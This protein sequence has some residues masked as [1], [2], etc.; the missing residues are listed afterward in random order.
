[1]PQYTQPSPPPPHAMIYGQVTAQ[2]RTREITAGPTRQD[3]ASLIVLIYLPSMCDEKEREIQRL[4]LAS[5]VQK[6]KQKLSK[7]GKQ[8]QIKP[9]EIC[10]LDL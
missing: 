5:L 1:M 8:A 7:E 9:E 3:D 6:M 2:Q 10:N 4:R